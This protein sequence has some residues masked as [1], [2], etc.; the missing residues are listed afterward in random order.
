MEK[1]LL[2]IF[3]TN[4][5]T[6]AVRYVYCNCK[7]PTTRFSGSNFEEIAIYQEWMSAID[8]KLEMSEMGNTNECQSCKW[9][10]G[11]Q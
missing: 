6:C 1:I 5:R 7:V 9:Q 10:H 8:L 3:S 4:F 11:M 2:H